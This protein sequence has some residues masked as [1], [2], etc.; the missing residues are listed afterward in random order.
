[1][2]TIN[3][4]R[5]LEKHIQEK[6]DNH[7]WI[8]ECLCDRAEAFPYRVSTSGNPS[9]SKH[10]Y[11]P[12]LL[13]NTNTQSKEN[14]YPFYLVNIPLAHLP[15]DES[16]SRFKS[17]VK[18]FK[19]ESYGTNSAQSKIT[20]LERFA[21]VIG[22]NQIVSIDP[23][24]NRQFEDYMAKIPLIKGIAYRVFGFF[25][26]PTWSQESQFKGKIY[27]LNK[28]FL[29]LKALSEDNAK[30]VRETYESS[31]LGLHSNLLGQIPFQQIRETIK[32][33]TQTN[34]LA[35]HFAEQSAT[36]PIYYGV[37]DADCQSLRTDK[38]LFSRLDAAI[39]KHRT[40]SAITL[41][42]SVS[43]DERPLI[44]KGVEMDMKVREAMCK[45]FSFGAYFPEPGSFFC[46]R[47]PGHSLKLAKMSFIG[48][49]RAL[50]NRRLIQNG[51]KNNVLKDGVFIADGGITTGTP[52][53]MKTIKNGKV[54]QLSSKLIKEK[55][56]LQSLRGISQTHATP[57]QW[58]DNL[59]VA[60]DFSCSQVTD[61]TG[62]MMHI[63]SV[64]DPISRMFA[65]VGRYSSKIFDSVLEKYEEPL[66]EIAKEILKDAKNDL[67]K[68]GMKDSLVEKI[69]QAAK[70]SGLAIR[71]VLQHAVDD[72]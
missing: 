43:D 53:R 61:A 71:D 64:Y 55:Q 68:I 40:P 13:P 62:S 42:Y 45:V 63:F 5:F 11:L 22:I 32:S 31:R 29:V 16:Y 60:L 7:P 47:K 21:C 8:K 6:F 52:G 3:Q 18:L 46:I 58:A 37:M 69:E 10:I 19:D 14:K 12:D 54:E 26:Q 17:L 35:N 65:H 24:V 2:L 66:S 49:G 51:I 57:K 39:S 4:N 56:N 67:K 44:R 70:Q 41:G 59:Y 30:I 33:S 28:A 72:E 25:W 9:I 23:A 20:V 1:M 15:E 27:P 34:Y 38:G 48:L 50:E 36:S